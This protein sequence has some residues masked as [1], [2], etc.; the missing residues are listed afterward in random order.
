M[1]VVL[2]GLKWTH[3]ICFLDDVVTYGRTFDEH[4]QR[5]DDVLAAIGR[6][7]MKIK[8]RKCRFLETVLKVL[9]HIV[10]AD[11]VSCDPAKVKAIQEFP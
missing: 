4:L 7:G 8:L 6:S 9:G 2:G 1:D 3:A 5:L 11:G 10:S